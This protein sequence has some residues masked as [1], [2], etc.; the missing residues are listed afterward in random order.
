MSDFMD[1]EEVLYWY[2]SKQPKL[3]K[4]SC[5]KNRELVTKY[6]KK[7]SD[8]KMSKK[9]TKK[10]YTYNTLENQY[11]HVIIN[12]PDYVD[13]KNQH[14]FLKIYLEWAKKWLH[15]ALSAPE[16]RA[17]SCKKNTE[18]THMEHEK[19]SQSCPLKSYDDT[20]T[21]YR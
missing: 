11:D 12:P 1:F 20:V 2:Y 18:D 5:W 16:G 15:E 6:E 13:Y 3:K 7:M 4:K 10:L 9:R 19:A 8:L 21:L 17:S 14:E